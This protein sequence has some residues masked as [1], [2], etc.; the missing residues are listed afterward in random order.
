MGGF[1]GRGEDCWLILIQEEAIK[2]CRGNGDVHF[3]AD[4]AVVLSRLVWSPRSATRVENAGSCCN[5]WKGV[6]DL[7]FSHSSV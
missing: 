6:S 3:F 4:G 2:N 7:G 1:V 5:L